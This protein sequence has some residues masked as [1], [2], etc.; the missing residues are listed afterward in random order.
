MEFFVYPADPDCTECGGSGNKTHRKLTGT[1]TIYEDCPC[2]KP[3]NVA[4]V[5]RRCKHV[6]IC[7]V[8]GASSP[9][10][11]HCEHEW[12][13]RENGRNDRWIFMGRFCKKCGLY[14]SESLIDNPDP[15]LGF[16]I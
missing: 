3:E 15:W 6:F 4:K 2:R 11:S 9:K 16:G 1:D 8:C 10:P 13:D 12:E 5:Q 14:L 7:K